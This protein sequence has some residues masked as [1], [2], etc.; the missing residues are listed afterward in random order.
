[1]NP[2]DLLSECMIA[3]NTG[4]ELTFEAQQA[5]ADALSQWAMYA[6][7]LNVALGLTGR[8]GSSAKRKLAIHGRDNLL[9]SAHELAPGPTPWLRSKALSERL[10]RLQ[11]VKVMRSAS[12]FDVAV[13]KVLDHV[14]LHELKLPGSTTSIHRVITAPHSGF[15]VA[16]LDASFAADNVRGILDESQAQD[17]QHESAA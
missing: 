12:P 3:A 16:A 14:R 5:L 2:L 13:A 6:T 8:G 4:D 10:K 9:L 1:M 7:P 15:D 11:G 17:D